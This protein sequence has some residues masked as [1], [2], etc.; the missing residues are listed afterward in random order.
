MQMGHERENSMTAKAEESRTDRRSFL[1][2]AGLG[3]VASGAALVTGEKSEAAETS[4]ATA[5]DGYR[6]TDHVKAYYKSARF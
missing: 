3:S 4:A 1:K 6:E 5:G 2:L